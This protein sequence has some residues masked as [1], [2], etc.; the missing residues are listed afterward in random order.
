MMRAALEGLKAHAELGEEEVCMGI[1]ELDGRA[2]E[3]RCR[4][5]DGG[6]R[7]R[8]EW[9]RRWEVDEGREADAR[10]RWRV[11]RVLDVRRPE[12]RRGR[13]IEVQVEWAG[14]H[15]RSGTPWSVEWVAITWC[16]SD[17]REEARRQERIRYPKLAGTRSEVGRA[18]GWRGT[19]L[20]VRRT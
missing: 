7:R 12:H 20:G 4:W 10:G 13:Q 6:G 1:G 9:L 14:V 2:Y 11:A 5:R 15:T 16:T 3:A 18:R 17:V 8:L 19:G